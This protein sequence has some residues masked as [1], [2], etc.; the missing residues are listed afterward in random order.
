MS[1]Q[2]SDA[3][4]G[5]SYTAS[6]K[7]LNSV[8]EEIGILYN[9]RFAFDPDSFSKISASFTITDFS[10][11]RFLEFLHSEYRIESKL[12]DGTWVLLLGKKVNPVLPSKPGKKK[13]TVSGYIK[14]KITG[15][16]LIYCNVSRE[17]GKGA[18]TNELGFFYFEIQETD[19][20]PLKI[21]HLG[22]RQ[23]DTLL[24]AAESA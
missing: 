9:L 7:P 4:N 13:M 21:S 20:V 12:I 22:Y 2:L 19:S 11:N 15:E 1:I 5:I 24:N 8:L 3:Q 16:D 23:L 18:M 10:T 14:D 17:P 6:E